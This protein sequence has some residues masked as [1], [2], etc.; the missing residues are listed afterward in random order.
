MTRLKRL[1]IDVLSGVGGGL[2]FAL[3]AVWAI[4]HVRVGDGVPVESVTWMGL[5]IVLMLVR[6]N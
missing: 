5:G 4:E 6:K 1:V 2:L 3:G